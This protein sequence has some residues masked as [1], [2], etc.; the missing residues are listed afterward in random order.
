MQSSV[1]MNVFRRRALTSTRFV[2]PVAKFIRENLRE[3][4]EAVD[5]ARDSLDFPFIFTQDESSSSKLAK[6]KKYRKNAKN[7][8]DERVEPGYMPI[9]PKE[10][11]Y[12]KQRKKKLSLSS[13]SCV[14]IPTTHPSSDRQSGGTLP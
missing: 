11:K 12:C 5:R 14:S 2:R 1:F 13:G 7:K 3:Q 6:E 4:T 9:E 10:R 8:Q